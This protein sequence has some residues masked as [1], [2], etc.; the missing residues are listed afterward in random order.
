MIIENDRLKIEC[1]PEL[2]GRLVS[3]FHKKK[4]FE[5]AAQRKNRLNPLTRPGEDFGFYAFGMDDAFPNIEAER[6]NWKGRIYKYPDH[7]EI[8][9]AQFEVA[10][11]KKDSVSMCWKSQELEYF[12]ERTLYLRDNMLHI[13]YYI[14]NEGRDELPC[15]WTWHGLMRYEEDMEVILPKGITCCR[16]VLSG[17]VLGKQGVVYPLQNNIYDFLKVPKAESMS[18]IKFYVE[19]PVE[20][21]YCGFRYPSQ[22]ITCIMEYDAEL[23]PFLGVW[24]TAGGFYGDY[25]CAL[26]PGNGFYDSISTAQNN[27][28]LP[29]LA[30][31]ESMEFEIKITLE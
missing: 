5:L 12:Y 19:G 22:D 29:V 28:K 9:R 10:E 7:G 27:G 20:C 2:G 13:G 23:L 16:N 17:S 8:W 6:I 3:F 25:N 11:W 21:G 26:E 14:V 30:V 24:I 1:F 4:G 18:M 15:F 31:G